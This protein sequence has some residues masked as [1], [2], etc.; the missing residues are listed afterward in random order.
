MERLSVPTYHHVESFSARGGR[1][2]YFE[3]F[4]D[5]PQDGSIKTSAGLFREIIY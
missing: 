4:W 3:S 2:I 5:K 1:H